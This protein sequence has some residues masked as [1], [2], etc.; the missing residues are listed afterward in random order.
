MLCIIPHAGA[1][2][3][4][5]CSSKGVPLY[6]VIAGT[7]LSLEILV[8]TTTLLIS[9]S[10]DNKTT[11]RTLRL[12]DCFAFFILIWILIGSNWIF[13]VS[14]N[15]RAC[16]ELDAETKQLSSDMTINA[17]DLFPVAT[18]AAT[19]EDCSDGV[20]QFAVGVII[21]QYMAVFCVIVFCCCAAMKK[22]TS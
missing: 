16:S 2:N 9:I 21:V 22:G 7:C 19:C 6:L 12:C 8:H 15:S 14:I 20:Y 1:L 3:F 17:T 10:T 5:V 13:K 11:N 4:N 18:T